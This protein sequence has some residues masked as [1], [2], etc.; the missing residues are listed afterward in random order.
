VIYLKYPEKFPK[1]N[2]PTKISE[3]GSVGV[4]VDQSTDTV[5]AGVNDIITGWDLGIA[6][7]CQGERRKIMMSAEMAYGAAGAFRVIPPGVPLV[8]DVEIIKVENYAGVQQEEEARS[9]RIS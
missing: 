9:P 8:L 3:A 7:A 5:R 2:I 1:S 4:M 6:S